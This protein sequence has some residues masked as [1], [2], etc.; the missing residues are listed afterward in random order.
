MH[1]LRGL[2]VPR[3]AS[4]LSCTAHPQS[5]APQPWRIC[6]RKGNLLYK[7]NKSRSVRVFLPLVMTTMPQKPAFCQWAAP[8]TLRLTRRARAAL[9]AVPT[10]AAPDAGSGLTCD[11]LRAN[12]WRAQGCPEGFRAGL[13]APYPCFI[14]A[15]SWLRACACRASSATACAAS[16]MAWAVWLDISFTCVMDWLISSLAADCS[17]LAVAIAPT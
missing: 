10:M 7:S 13:N 1:G 5:H 14:S 16:P 6:I 11:G 3:G 2:A 17:S 15:I 9:V 4:A 12:L 8:R